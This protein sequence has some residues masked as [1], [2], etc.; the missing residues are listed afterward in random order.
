M[1]ISSIN[2]KKKILV[3]LLIIILT[4]FF[5]ELVFG[6]F[7]L[8]NK[9]DS[10][11]IIFKP[12]IN[13]SL[14]NLIQ[15]NE[16]Y[17]FNTNKYIPGNYKNGNIEYY[18]NS[19]GFR[20]PEYLPNTNN[21]LL[22]AYG[23]STTIGIEV[24]Y[25][26]T[27]PRILEKKME[28]GYDV[29]NF[30][31]SSKSLKYIFERILSEFSEYKPDF[32]IIY[33]NRNSAMYDTL[34]GKLS[35]DV[36]TNKTSYLIFKLN[37][38]LENNIMSFKFF[39]N[40]YLRFI[41][42]KVGVP[43]PSDISR[44]INLDYLSSGYLS[45]LE[46]IYNYTKEDSKLVVVKQI[47]YIDS[48]IQKRLENNDIEK[49]I[50][51]LKNYNNTN[52][53]TMKYDNNLNQQEIID[54]YFILTNV[55]LNQQLDILKSKYNEVTVVDPLNIFYNFNKNETTTDGLHLNEL[56]NEILA[57]SIFKAIK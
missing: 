56:G 1:N 20:G 22:I 53:Q 15:R 50:N 55:I 54:N 47:Y 19:K 49:N 29:L 18:I 7:F 39:K 17:D 34:E 25:E 31:V 45:L 9:S 26:D 24:S 3:N 21:R 44:S 11:S 8:I 41:Q 28:K 5:F 40:I 37:Y 46:Q 12:F 2:I 27:F 6:I 43:H 52:L 36:F 42:I 14:N 48:E 32:I 35:D 10:I 57:E 13:S 23:G 4:L 30:G 51:L 16:N 33:N 38:Y